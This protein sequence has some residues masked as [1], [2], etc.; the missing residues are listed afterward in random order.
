MTERKTTRWS[1]SDRLTMKRP[2]SNKAALK[3]AL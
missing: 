3:A 2:S 1:R